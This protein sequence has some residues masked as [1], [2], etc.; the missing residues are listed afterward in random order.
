MLETHLEDWKYSSCCE[1]G[2]DVKIVMRGRLCG[3]DGGIDGCPGGVF[4][5]LPHVFRG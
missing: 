2:S 3:D 5:F 1:T 4:R